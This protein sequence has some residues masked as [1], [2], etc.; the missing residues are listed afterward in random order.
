MKKESPQPKS[1]I[2][3]LLY[4][5]DLP[6]WLLI[7]LAVVLILRIPSFFEPYSYGDEMIYL[8]LGNAIR[9]GITIYKDIYDNKPPLIYLMAGVAGSLFWFKVILA[10][11]NL[12][13]IALFWH[14]AQALFPGKDRL[15]KYATTIFAILTTIPLLEGNIVNAELFMIG[16]IIAAFLILIKKKL[17]AKNLVF[18]GIL[19]SIAALFKIPAAFD[20]PTI[21]VFW[22]ITQG[23]NKEN[24]KNVFKNTLF[25]A[26]GFII[27]FILVSIWLYTRGALKDFIQAALM[28][29]VG[30]LSSWRPTATKVPFLVKNA[31]LLIRA[32][33]VAL[34]S[35]IL[36]IFRKKLSK[37]FIFITLW[38][39]FTLFAVTLSERPYPHYLIQTVAPLS[40]L[41]GMLF[42]E[43]SL[44][45]SFVIIPLTLTFLVP[46]YYKFWYYSST[47]YYLRF[48]R[49]AT[50]MISKDKYLTEYGSNV[51]RNYQ[52]AEFLTQSTLPSDKVFITG[53]SSVIYALSQRF[54][55][56]K[57]VADYH[58]NDF[59]SKEEEAKIIIKEKPKFIIV[60]PEANSFPQIMSF[61]KQS[62]I[63]VSEIEGAQIWLLTSH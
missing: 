48:V 35:A 58:I 38:S 2:V 16:P 61:L 18:S 22:L 21:I 55:P 26:V 57:Y 3:K 23:L 60:L 11:W 41:F 37:Q 33:I 12:V 10:F 31:P 32:G 7:L 44:E 59:S 30:Y 19:F 43:K 4:K 15:H 47:P 54:P 24:I 29:N 8:T 39:L 40:L 56:G 6:N 42:T 5:I 1:F 20:L 53:D 36:L 50:G 62:Y 45:Q 46:V 28:Q 14:F 52:I 25:L 51:P 27:P 34:G 49:F 63:Q 9:R 17:T 13:T